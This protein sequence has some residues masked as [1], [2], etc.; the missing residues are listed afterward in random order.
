MIG[1]IGLPEMDGYALIE[2]IRLN[3]RGKRSPPIALTAYAVQEDVRAG[4]GL[5]A[6]FDAHVAKPAEPGSPPRPGLLPGEGETR[7]WRGRVVT[8]PRV[9]P[10]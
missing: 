2:R 9:E 4:A 3:N 1:G 6:G 5:E 10:F 8:S 7:V